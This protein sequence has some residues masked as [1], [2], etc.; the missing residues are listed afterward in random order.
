MCTNLEQMFHSTKKDIDLLLAFV[1]VT[2]LSRN[3]G[4]N[5]YLLPLYYSAS[6]FQQKPTDDTSGKK[7]P[8][9]TSLEAQEECYD[10]S[11]GSLVQHYLKGGCFS[12]TKKQS[13]KEAPH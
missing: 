13:K 11:T 2:M 5:A 3:K 4:M 7:E 8:R 12:K 9:A 1:N 6:L 10:G